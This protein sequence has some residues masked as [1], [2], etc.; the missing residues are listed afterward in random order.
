MK[1][2]REGLISQGVS[3]FSSGRTAQV[4][5]VIARA[6]ARLGNCANMAFLL[7]AA[8][9]SREPTPV[10]SGGRRLVRR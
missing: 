5:A 2:R 8:V 3:S 1:P 6:L 10:S 9:S 4:R 7:A